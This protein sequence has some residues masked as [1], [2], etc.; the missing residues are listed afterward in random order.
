MAFQVV[1]KQGDTLPCHVHKIPVIVTEPNR[2]GLGKTNKRLDVAFGPL[3]LPTIEKSLI[4]MATP[5]FLSMIE[6]QGFE[7]FILAGMEVHLYLR[8][9]CYPPNGSRMFSEK[10]ASRTYVCCN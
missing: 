7:S 1:Q 8:R 3:H 4:S 9:A 5:V 2:R 10:I 6:S